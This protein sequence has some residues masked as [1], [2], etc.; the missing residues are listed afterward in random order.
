MINLISV[1]APEKMNT[2][3][4]IYICT[5][6]AHSIKCCDVFSRES[7]KRACMNERGNNVINY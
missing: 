5:E 7:I 1:Q 6:Q 3:L 2:D 4:A